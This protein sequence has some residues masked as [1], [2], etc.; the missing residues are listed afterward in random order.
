MCDQKSLGAELLHAPQIGQR[1]SSNSSNSLVGCELR[2]ESSSRMVSLYKTQEPK[3]AGR[4][5]AGSKAATQN[6]SHLSLEGVAIF[7]VEW[8]GGVG[9]LLLS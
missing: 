5:L 9:S 6:Q 3:E 8:I 7:E 2:R 1:P 4:R